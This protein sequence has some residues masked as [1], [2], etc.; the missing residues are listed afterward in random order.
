MDW[1][2]KILVFLHDY[3][4]YIAMIWFCV[5]QCWI[6]FHLFLLFIYDCSFFF[7]LCLLRLIIAFKHIVFPECNYFNVICKTDESVSY[8]V[9][10]LLIHSYH[11]IFC[12]QIEQIIIEDNLIYPSPSC[13]FPAAMYICF[14]TTWYVNIQD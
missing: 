3:I 8:F 7:S 11:C 13:F 14:C 6:D 10:S 5:T 1:P 12:E 9:F 2:S 4:T